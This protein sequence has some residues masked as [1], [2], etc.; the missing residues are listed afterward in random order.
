MVFSFSQHPR[1]TTSAVPCEPLLTTLREKTEILSSYGIDY[2]CYMDFN[3]IIMKKSPDEFIRQ[4]LVKRLNARV[5]IHGYNYH[6][7]H[8]ASGDGVILKKR[9]I[10]YGFITQT[11]A[12]V[13]FDKHIVSSSF[14]R[15]LIKKGDISS[16]NKYLGR[17]YSV[18]ARIQL[19]SSSDHLV[20]SVRF[21]PEKILPEKGSFKIN[22]ET[23]NCLNKGILNIGKRNSVIEIKNKVSKEVTL[24]ISA[25]IIFER[26]LRDI[27]NYDI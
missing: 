19:K 11:I 8:M 15:N 26:Q 27:I 7:G 24:N 6:F 12:P 9:G 20:Y 22:I 4:I 16:A 3:E 17:N 5:L 10:K 18:S 21:D 23:E 2:F 13:K 1:N 25:R 14:V